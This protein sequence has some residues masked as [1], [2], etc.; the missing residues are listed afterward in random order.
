[1]NE[2]P[3]DRNAEMLARHFEAGLTYSD[4][5]ATGE[6]G[7]QERWSSYYRNI[8]LTGEQR[9]LLSGFNRNINVL[10]LSGIWCG[11]CMRQCPILQHFAE[12]CSRLTL[13]FVDN[14]ANPE[15]RDILRINGGARVPVAL[16]LSE[17][18]FEVGRFGDRTLSTY[19]RKAATELGDACDAGIVPPSDDA[20]ALEVQEWLNE[21]ER[22]HLIL[23]LSPMLRKRYND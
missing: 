2:G 14:H 12:A 17:D 21:L 22:A 10:V 19:R 18:F 11:D 8:S 6:S 9:S 20:M 23:R 1:M 4:Y 13:R 7:Q 15:L 16:F 5:L 3:F